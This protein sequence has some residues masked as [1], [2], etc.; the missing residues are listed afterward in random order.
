MRA[1]QMTEA[2]E[3]VLCEAKPVMGLHRD[4]GYAEYA[5]ARA[6]ALA[7]IPEEAETAVE[8]VPLADAEAAY[9]AMDAGEVRYRAVVVP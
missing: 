7:A 3:F 5:T 2:G 1:V 6:G 9:R 8:T 4:G